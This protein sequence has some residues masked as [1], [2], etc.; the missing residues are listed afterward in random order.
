MWL[1]LALA[2]CRVPATFQCESSDQCTREGPTGTCEPNGFCSFPDS[3]CMSG[4]SYDA[5]AGVLAG[6]CVAVPPPDIDAAVSTS[7]Q[8]SPQ[9][10]MVAGL[11]H[12]YRVT[13]LVD[14]DAAT[15]ACAAD[16]A[17]L[18]TIDDATENAAVVAL[19][20]NWIGFDDLTTEGRFVWQHAPTATYANFNTGEPN[21]YQFHEDCVYVR[22][23]G[24]WNDTP[25][26]EARP[27]LCECEAGYTAPTIPAC[28]AMPG[29]TIVQG[30]RYFVHT[31]QHVSWAEA[32]ADCESTGAY[33]MVVGDLYENFFL[34]N[35]TGLPMLDLWLGASRPNSGD[36]WSWVDGAPF[37]FTNWANNYPTGDPDANCIVTASANEKWQNARCNDA[38][39]YVCE[40]DPLPP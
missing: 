29:A 23:D 39:A 7:C 9:Y 19:A 4:R 31:A 34:D 26:G 30:R 21:N 22:T 2:G 33:L 24:L 16:N 17:Y 8:T 6:T 38:H 10:Q 12:T 3:Q 27:G 13:G 1:A 25:C 15:A 20:A 32:K 37:V 35:T 28:M 18:A 14:Y 36:P 40:C 11:T 5:S